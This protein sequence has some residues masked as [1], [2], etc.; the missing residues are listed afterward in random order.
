MTNLFDAAI[1]WQKQLLDTQRTALEAGRHAHDA[2]A[3]LVAAQE[4][5]RRAAEAN[6]AAWQAWAQ[7]S[8]IAP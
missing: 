5:S 1:N 7:L 2:G 6:W 3:A 4:A 8:R